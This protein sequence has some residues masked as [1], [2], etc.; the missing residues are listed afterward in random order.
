MTDYL[1]DFALDGPNIRLVA[2]HTISCPKR[3]L[4]V[5]EVLVRHVGPVRTNRL[6]Q[7]IGEVVA[8]NRWEIIHLAIEPDHVHLFIRANPATMPSDIPR[9]ITVRSSHRDA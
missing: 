8:E 9:R 6:V 3:G 1:Q 2:Y 5:L 7:M 4:E